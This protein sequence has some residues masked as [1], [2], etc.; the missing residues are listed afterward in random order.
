MPSNAVCGPGTYRYV[1]KSD[2]ACQF[3]AGAMTDEARS[4]LISDPKRK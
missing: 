4:A 3:G 1:K 2:M